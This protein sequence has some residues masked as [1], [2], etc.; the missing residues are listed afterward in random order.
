M[1]FIPP[2]NKPRLKVYLYQK[3]DFDSMRRDSS[4]LAEDKCFSG[5]SGSRSVQENFSLT[6]SFIQQAVD[7][8]KT[9]RSVASVL[10]LHLRLEGIFEKGIK[11]M[12]RQKRLAEVNQTQI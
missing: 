9:S 5:H 2:R 3:G 8:Y 7:K 12:Q 4:N 11:L 10:G 6:A 1:V